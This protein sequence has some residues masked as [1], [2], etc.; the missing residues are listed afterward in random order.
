MA[1]RVTKAQRVKATIVAERELLRYADDHAMWHKHVH[2]VELDTMQVLKCIEM[3]QHRNT[4]DFSCR[5]TGKTAIKEMYN[6]KQL[7]TKADQELGIVAP[8]MAQSEVN[9]RYMI[10]AIQ[11]SPILTAFLGYERGRQ[12]LA[13]SHFTFGNRSRAKAYGIMANVDGGDLTMASLE[14]V[15]D[16]PLDRLNSRFLLMM[17]STRR[18]GASKQSQN[19]PQIRVTG[20]FKGADTLTDLIARGHYHVLPTV[21]AYMGIEL[22]I[23]NEQ[24]IQMMRDELAP[25]EYM[26]QLLCK[27]VSARNLIWE[28]WVRRSIQTG[29]RAG[30]QMFSPLPGHVYQAVGPVVLGYDA[31]GHGEDPQSSKHACTVWEVIGSFF[32]PRYAKTWSAGA[33]ESEVVAGLM[34]IFRYFRPQNALGDA[35][36]IGVIRSVNEMCLHEGLTDKDPRAIGDGQSTATNWPSWY[37]SPI[38]FEGMV[39]HQMAQAL[40]SLFSNGQVAMPYV[41]DLPLSDPE[42]ADMHLL[43]HQLPNIKKEQTSKSYASYKMANRK[44]GDDLFDA[45]MAAVWAMVNRIVDDA[46]ASWLLGAPRSRQSMLEAHHG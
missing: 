26:R 41:D 30:V 3:D 19:D 42:V 4:I 13:D 5:R 33:D 28:L 17:G 43:Q 14:E 16:M 25:D 27:N 37:F 21:D 32:V 10:E 6:L 1:E 39:K 35:F 36:G 22:G 24:F 45:S 46:P 38:R 2:N 9:M 34:S 23:L 12:L 7:A 31:G 8:R 44:L 11:R 29:L 20:V 18:L 40:R 15:D